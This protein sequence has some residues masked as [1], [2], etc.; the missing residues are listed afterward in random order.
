MR[1]ASSVGSENSKKALRESAL[2]TR[3]SLDQA[4]V[5]PLNE[6]IQ[7]NLYSLNEF[8]RARVLACYVATKDEVQTEGIIRT[9]LNLSKTIL[10]PLVDRTRTELLFSELRDFSELAEGH[11]GILE[12]RIGFLRIA[13]LE[14]ADIVLVPLVA[15][16]ERG[17]RIG[18]GKGYFDRALGSLK[19]DIPTIGLAFEAQRVERVPDEPFDVPLRFIVTEQRVLRFKGGEV[20]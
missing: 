4:V 12:P 6:R 17:F 16:D 20:R 9:S 5:K 11:Y 1:S 13:P 18:H 7:R 19:K 2:R 8:E 3:R 15:W 14:K 10:V